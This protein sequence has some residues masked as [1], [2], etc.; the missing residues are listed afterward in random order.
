MRFA[1]TVFLI[2]GIYG[3]LIFTPIYFMEARIGQETP[4]PRLLTRN[5]FMGFWERRW[6][7]SFC[8]WCCRKIHCDTA[9]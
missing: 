1:K 2:A 3:V 6:H 5:I 8:F 9:R 4:P 7:G